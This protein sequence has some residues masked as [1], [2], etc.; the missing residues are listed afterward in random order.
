MHIDALKFKKVGQFQKKNRNIDLILIPIVLICSNPKSFVAFYLI[1]SLSLM[2]KNT[3]NISK[4]LHLIR[5]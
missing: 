2:C 5:C 3:A 4:I 1:C